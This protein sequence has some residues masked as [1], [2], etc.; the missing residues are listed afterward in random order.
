MSEEAKNMTESGNEAAK[1]ASPEVEKRASETLEAVCGSI[2]A[3]LKEEMEKRGM[4]I[5][6]L[7][8]TSGLS[9]ATVSRLVSGK[10]NPRVD[11][12]AVLAAVLGVQ[13]EVKLQ[14]G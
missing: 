11:T 4:T 14:V 5:G 9:R 12:L 3:Q 6:E 8:N 13:V 2:S 10:G 1:G 7:V